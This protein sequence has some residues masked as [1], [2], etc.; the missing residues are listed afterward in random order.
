M[1]YLSIDCGRRRAAL[2]H[3]RL[4]LRIPCQVN[5]GIMMANRFHSYGGGGAAA[6][7]ILG[8]QKHPLSTCA[9]QCK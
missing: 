4:P 6:E 2:S 1:K 5:D 8:V 3:L 9:P 7:A